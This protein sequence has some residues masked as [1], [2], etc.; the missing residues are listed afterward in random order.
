MTAIRRTQ[1]LSHLAC[2]RVNVARQAGPAS[3]RLMLYYQ[4]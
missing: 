3:M 1:P 2:D 4:A